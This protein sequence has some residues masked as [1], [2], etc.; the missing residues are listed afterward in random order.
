MLVRVGLRLLVLVLQLLNGRRAHGNGNAVVSVMLVV[1]L[2][3]LLWLLL[4]VVIFKQMVQCAA[5]HYGKDVTHGTRWN[6]N[7][8]ART[9]GADGLLR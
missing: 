2:V 4:L 8:G 9:M 5:A 1:V 7:D 6:D 3:L